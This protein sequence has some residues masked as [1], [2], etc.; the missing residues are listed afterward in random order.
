MDVLVSRII[1]WKVTAVLVEIA[2]DVIAKPE[3]PDIQFIGNML[4]ML[5]H[6]LKHDS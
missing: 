3:S 5:K 2:I 4:N 6:E 1:L